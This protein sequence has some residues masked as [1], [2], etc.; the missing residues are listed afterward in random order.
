MGSRI[1]L[2][3]VAGI[4]GAAALQG[5]VGAENAARRATDFRYTPDPEVMRVLAGGDR[6]ACADMLWLSALPDMARPFED[7]ALKKRWIAAAT[8][9]ITD[10]EPTFGTVYGY[11]AAHLNLVDRNPDEAIA[12]LTKGIENNPDSA[13]LH[14]ALAMVWYEFKKDTAKAI[15]HLEKASELPGIDSLSLA[16]LAS[17]RVNGRDDFTALAVWAKQLDVAHNAKVRTICEY[18]LWRTKALIA[19]RAAREFTAAHG[20]PPANA[21]E[22]RDP[23][24]ISATA[25]DVVL[26]GL[27]FDAKGRPQYERLL[28]LDREQ[29]IVKAENY[30]AGRVS[31]SGRLPTAVEFFAGFGELP[32]PGPGRKWEYA[33]GKLSLAAAD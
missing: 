31:E 26:E 11:G 15:E 13:G 29:V 2:V 23:T 1:L 8:D 17:M 22:L 27:T 32:A 14:V 33:D 19:G 18:E 6:S 25:L 7:K 12:L 24:L 21:E 9:V 4:A 5:R 16:M 30:V 28:E 10:L 3:A 20:R